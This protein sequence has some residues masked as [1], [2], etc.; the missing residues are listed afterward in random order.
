MASNSNVTKLLPYAGKWTTNTLSSYEE[1]TVPEPSLRLDLQK[2]W[3]NQVIFLYSINNLVHAFGGPKPDGKNR[4]SN[5]IP[6]FPVYKLCIPRVF[7]SEPYNF[8]YIKAPNRVFRSAPSLNDQYLNWLDRIQQDKADIWQACVF[9]QHFPLRMWYDDSSTLLDVAAITGL[10]PLGD[11]YDPFKASDTI[12]FDFRNKSYSKYIIENQK[13]DDEV[14]AEEHVAFLTLWL[15]QYVFCTQ[16]L[17]VAKKYIPMA[18]QLHECQQFSF[19]RL[20]LGCLYES[21]RDACEHLK[22]TGD[23]STFLGAGPF[24]LL[25]LWLNATFHTEL[26]LFLPEQFYDESRAR[27]VEGTRLARLAPR[28][29]GVFLNLKKFKPSFAPFVDR[30]LGPP[31]FTQHFPSPPDFEEVVTSIW[32][33][34][35]MPTVLSCRIGLTA[36]EFGLVGYFPNLVSRQF[37]L[38]QILSKSIYLEEREICLGKYGMTEPQY[39]SFLEHFTKSSYE[40]TPFEFAPSHACTKEFS[41][42]WSLHYEGRLVDRTVLLTAISNGFDSSILNKIKSKLNT[43]G[44]KSKAGSSSSNKPPLPPP[45][46]EL[47]VA[48]RKR[49]HPSEAPS[50]SKKQKPVPVAHSSAADKD[51]PILST[52]HEQTTTSTIQDPPHTDQPTKDKK[53]KKRRKD[54]KSNQLASSENHPSEVEVLEDTSKPPKNPPQE[55]SEKKKKKKKKKHK[56]SPISTTAAETPAVTTEAPQVLETALD[57]QAQPQNSPQTVPQDNLSPNK[58][59]KE[60]VEEPV[61][62]QHETVL[63]RIPSPQPIESSIPNKSPSPKP[64]GSPDLGAGN[65]TFEP[66]NGEV[67]LTQRPS[68]ES[69]LLDQTQMP[70]TTEPIIEAVNAEAGH[71]MGVANEQGPPLEGDHSTTNQPQPSGPSH[72]SGSMNA[73]TFDSDDDDSQTGDSYDEEGTSVSKPPPS[74]YLPAELAKELKDLA[75]ADALN[76]LLSSH[77]AS[78]PN[79]EDKES[80]L[81]KKQFDHELRFRRE[82]LHGDMLG[83]L[84]RDSSIYFN[85][86]ALFN[87]LQNPRTSEAIFLLVTQAEAYLEQYVN[88]PQLLSRTDELLKSQLSAQQRLFD[89]AAHCNAEVSRIKATSF[90]ALNQIVT[91]ED[92]IAKWQY[93]IE[94]LKEKIRQEEAKMERLATLAVEVHRA[95]IDEL[96]H[97]GLQHYSDCLAVQ[98]QV[99]RLT[100]DKEMLQRKLV[101]IRN[102]YYQ[103]QTAN[104]KPFF[105][106]TATLRLL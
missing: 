71:D 26:D 25:Q 105:V 42:W 87:K 7:L 82:I 72:C 104:Q 62:A 102:Q 43:R 58:V 4:N 47:G 89:Q 50:S 66:N 1:G 73:N 80:L 65:S 45:K 18:I 48:S 22:K 36:G 61:A 16:S 100:N 39:R 6:I 29:R 101:S 11:T 86:K 23:G 52:I 17:Q 95:K 67:N 74:I 84:E 79:A 19:A 56:E 38:T 103:F 31:W 24:W 96:A 44:S 41:K 37:G 63:E 53:K 9:Y 75:P 3:E 21:M 70:N 20:I 88:Q 97:E 77:G 5:T 57:S 14:S 51:A 99:E 55:H 81:E 90:D 93:E 106:T 34:Y 85:I 69:P 27:Q 83:L 35:L 49:L 32:S 33:A 40:L 68:H 76:K 30:P 2:I 54:K 94:E 78:N 10:S 15:S 59:V 64:T 98:R 28:V 91:C 8:S 12:K 60:V 13:T 46:V 92:N